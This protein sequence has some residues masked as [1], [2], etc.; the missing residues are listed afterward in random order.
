MQIAWLER[1]IAEDCTNRLL[2]CDC[3]MQKK[4]EENINKRIPHGARKS[5]NAAVRFKDLT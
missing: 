5:K 1:E 4:K 3:D 2:C